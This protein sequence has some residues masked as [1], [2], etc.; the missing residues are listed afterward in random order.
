[1]RPGWANS[2][3]DPF[4]KISNKKIRTG[5]VAQ[6]IEYLPSKREVLSSIPNPTKKRIFILELFIVIKH[7]GSC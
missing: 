7:I 1:L 4:L 2:W 3:R 6:V 5:R